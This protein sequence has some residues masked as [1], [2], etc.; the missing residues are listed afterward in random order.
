METLTVALKD[1][2]RLI[3]PLPNQNRTPSSAITPKGVYCSENKCFSPKIVKK[4]SNTFS[5]KFIDD[6]SA[7][8]TLA[9]L[10]F[11]AVVSL[12]ALISMNFLLAIT[13]CESVSGWIFSDFILGIIV[14]F[15]FYE[16]AQATR[17]FLI[18]NPNSIIVK[19]KMFFCIPK[20]RKVYNSGELKEAVIIYETESDEDT[21]YYLYKFY[22]IL[23]SGK[24]DAFFALKVSEKL[25][26]KDFYDFIDLLNDHIENHMK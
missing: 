22:L 5:L 24:K 17:D 3:Y 18:L 23:K 1:D 13:G 12:A 15:L 25:D 6:S 21:K 10:I 20:R 14:I 4:G 19:S 8:T 11:F 16:L 7:C 2:N 9:V 26:I